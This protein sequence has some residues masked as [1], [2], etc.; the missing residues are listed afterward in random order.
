MRPGF[1]FLHFHSVSYSFRPKT[2]FTK[3]FFNLLHPDR[4]SCISK[5]AKFAMLGGN[6]FPMDVALRYNQG[7]RSHT[8]FSTCF[9]VHLK[10]TIDVPNG[11]AVAKSTLDILYTHLF[12]HRQIVQIRH[13]HRIMKTTN[14]V[15]HRVKERNRWST[16]L[17]NLQR[18]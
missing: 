17:I 3:L 11:I 10:V 15:N 9:I 1:Y 18:L 14:R 5:G 4:I 12:L 13:I 6:G 2:N 8:Y 16:C 7:K